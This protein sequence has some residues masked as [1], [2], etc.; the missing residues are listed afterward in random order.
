MYISVINNTN[1]RLTQVCKHEIRVQGNN[2]NTKS[3][4]VKIFIHTKSIFMGFILFLEF[5]SSFSFK[6]SL[7]NKWFMSLQ[8]TAMLYFLNHKT[9]SE[10]D[11]YGVNFLSSLIS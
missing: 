3:N 10:M 1:L 5:D 11:I 9:S 7:G 8:T 6:D 4:V 2:V